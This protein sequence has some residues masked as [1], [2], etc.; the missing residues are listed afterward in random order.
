MKN[1]VGVRIETKNNSVSLNNFKHNLRTLETAGQINNNDNILI[2]NNQIIYDNESIKNEY[3]NLVKIREEIIQEH[4]T[5]YKENNRNRK[6]PNH[7]SSVGEGVIYFSE[8]I[9]DKQMTDSNFTNNF[10][11]LAEKASEEICRRLKTKPIYIS[12]HLDEKTPHFH[13]HFKNFDDKGKSLTSKIIQEHKIEEI[14]EDRYNRLNK[15]YNE[16]VEILTFDENGENKII[17]PKPKIYKD[18]GKYTEKI[19]TG[20]S[21]LQDIVGEVYK[22]YGFR[23]GQKKENTG[24]YNQKTRIWLENQ[25]K[26]TENTIIDNNQII[27]NQTLKLD[28]FNDDI[29]KQYKNLISFTKELRKTLSS[30]TTMT[31]DDKKDTYKEISEYQRIIRD[32]FKE[33][34]KILNQEITQQTSSEILETI[35]SKYKNLKSH[36]KITTEK[37]GFGDDKI[38]FDLKEFSTQFKK[39]SKELT[40]FETIS[41]DNINLK[42]TIETMKNTH[43]TEIEET[44]TQVREELTSQHQEANK[45]LQNNYDKLEEENKKIPKLEEEST[46]K[47]SIIETLTNQVNELK[48]T[49]TTQTSVIEELEEN[50]R[51][52]DRVV[53]HLDENYSKIYQEIDDKIF[54]EDNQLDSIRENLPELSDEEI[55]KEDSISNNKI[56]LK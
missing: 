54:I 36:G 46:D 35:K 40:K 4:E 28:N 52:N 42:E 3:I 29:S 41:Q 56:K 21:S 19:M 27:K 11:G 49:I 13:F 45:E 37:F 12:I 44:K 55:K 23:R 31:K 33:I 39:I 26:K 1:Y 16:K 50:G 10:T 17:V 24:K 53:N 5:I 48:T 2:I 9:K 38:T 43:K 22:E 51:F 7:T 8:L 32:D 18:N 6:L 30:D 20:L 47:Q 15:E 34:K 14:D 25:C